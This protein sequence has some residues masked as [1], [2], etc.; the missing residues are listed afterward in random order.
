MPRNGGE[1]KGLEL[2]PDDYD[3][4]Q[5]LAS[6]AGVKISSPA[7]FSY[8]N[9]SLTIKGT[10]A[11]ENFLAYRLQAGKGL[12][13]ENWVQIGEE[14]FTPVE[15]GVLGVWDTSDL[16]GL[17]AI[18]LAVQRA[19]N[20]VETGIIQVTVD[21]TPPQAGIFYPF[22]EEEISFTYGKQVNFSLEYVDNVGGEQG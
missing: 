22:P 10:A 13:P 14:K 17:Y 6:V 2:P 11:G 19:D 15:E 21:N 1:V 7:I 5:A 12:N 8:V 16:D 3:T 20:Q 9:G 18:R 4:I